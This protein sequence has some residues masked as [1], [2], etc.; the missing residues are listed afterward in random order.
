MTSTDTPIATQVAQLRKTSSTRLPAQVTAAFDDEM[1]RSVAVGV[2]AGVARPGSPM[3]DG[4]LLDPTG[5]STSLT[6][7]R[8]GRAAVVVFY[9][10]S[11]CPYCNLT[12]RVYQNE[13]VTELDAR[14]VALIA[15]SPQSPDGSLTTAQKNELSF[16]VLS[17]PGLV[18]A[19]QLGMVFT[20]SPRALAAQTS[21]GLHLADENADGTARLP[22]A[23]TLVIDKAGIIDWIDVH[24]D[25]TTRSEPAEILA[26]VDEL[27]QH[28]EAQHR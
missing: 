4:E 17:D 9:R 16:P 23:T 5:R 24:P 21:L 12:L 25:Y 1:D 28:D 20:Q 14:G 15:V 7:V 26:A 22:L 3:P 18:L 10:G 6:Q 2:P 27:G 8:R 13:L 11:W 19:E